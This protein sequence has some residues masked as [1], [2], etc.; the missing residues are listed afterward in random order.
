MKNFSA[1]CFMMFVLLFSFV[2]LPYTVAAVGEDFLPP[3]V[4]T[5]PIENATCTTEYNPKEINRT[6]NLLMAVDIINGRVIAPGEVF[7]FNN[8]TGPTTKETGYKQA[9]IFVRGKEKQG[10]GGGI[11]QVSS[12]LYSAA[13]S[14]GFRI[15]ER[16]A[17]CRRVYYVPEGRD[18]AVAYGSV[19]FKF[20]NNM[21]YPVIIICF[22][23]DG[24]LTVALE[25]VVGY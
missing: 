17:H 21:D 13:K 4:F 1:L 8:E 22:A 18:A 20:E 3:Y 15:V 7:S 2:Q 10:Y 14:A 11:C 24:L 25:M 23:E 6:H 19:D 16:H 12:T 5:I 9:K